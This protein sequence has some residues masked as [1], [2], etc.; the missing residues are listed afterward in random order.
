M[1]RQ[2]FSKVDHLLLASVLDFNDISPGRHNSADEQQILQVSAMQLMNGQ[3]VNAHRHLPVSRNTIGTQECWVI[4]AG[5]VSVQVF[6][7]DQ[8][9]IDDFVLTTGNCLTTYR[10][11]HALQALQS[12]KILEI[13]NGPYYGAKF[14]SQPIN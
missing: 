4:L 12:A 8:M 3:K 1:I 11:G 6:D 13:K 2:I 9:Q 14:D 5:A 10:G 7:I